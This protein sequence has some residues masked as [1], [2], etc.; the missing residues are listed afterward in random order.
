MTDL[1]VAFGANQATLKSDPTSTIRASLDDLEKNSPVF[2]QRV[3]RMFVTKAFPLGSGPDFTNAAALISTDLASQEILPVLH[4]VEAK[5]G[6]N[7]DIRWGPR[8]LDLD[9]IGRGDQ[10]LPDRATVMSWM[11]AKPV[12]DVIPAPDQLIL[13]HPRLHERAFVLGPLQDVAPDWI[14]P[15]LDK[16]VPEMF[17]NL[18]KDDRESMKIID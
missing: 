11:K 15:I 13:P 16:S 14:H 6:R 1:I 17:A 5:F 7:R 10:I 2:I 12:E 3:S 18:P 9:F 8:S 4:G